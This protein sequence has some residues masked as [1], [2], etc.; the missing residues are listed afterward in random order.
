MNL[1][2]QTDTNFI[3]PTADRRLKFSEGV[4]LDVHGEYSAHV[5]PSIFILLFRCSVI[6]LFHVFQYPTSHKQL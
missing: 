3:V 6:P 2:R 5:H 4:W 1:P